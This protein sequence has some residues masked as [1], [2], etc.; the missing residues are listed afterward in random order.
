MLRRYNAWVPPNSAKL[1]VRKLEVIGIVIIAMVI[2]L[3]TL[4]RYGRQIPWGA[5]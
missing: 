2:L 4:I 1:L 3:I 5:R